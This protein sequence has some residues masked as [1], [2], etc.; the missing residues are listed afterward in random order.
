MGFGETIQLTTA[1]GIHVCTL[2][3][4]NLMEETEG[5]DEYARLDWCDV[6]LC[7]NAFPVG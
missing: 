6:N 4:P 5:L 7:S 2:A 3:I 1:M